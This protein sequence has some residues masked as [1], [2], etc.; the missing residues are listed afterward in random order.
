MTHPGET[1]TQKRYD[2]QIQPFQCDEKG[3]QADNYQKSTGEMQYAT[4]GMPM[5]T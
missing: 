2:R 4:N 1:I 5:L 3:E